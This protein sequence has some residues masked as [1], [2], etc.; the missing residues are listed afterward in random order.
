VEAGKI[1]CLLCLE[2]ADGRMKK[3]HKETK[4]GRYKEDAK[5]DA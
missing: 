1:H 4:H 2:M 5:E 3:I